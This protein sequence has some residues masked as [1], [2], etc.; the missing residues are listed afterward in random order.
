[1]SSTIK[2]AIRPSFYKS[3][4]PSPSWVPDR[5]ATLLRLVRSER[6]LHLGCADAPLTAAKLGDGGVLHQKV[7]AEAETVLGV[8]I[9]ITGLALLEAHV[10]GEYL[11]IDATD[12]AALVPA[13]STRPTIVLAADIIEHV[14]DT[15]SLLDA[16]AAFSARCA[17]PP[18][19]LLSTPNALSV[20]GPILAAAGVELVHPDHRMIFTPTTLARTLSIAGYRPTSWWTYP[21]S[22]GQS[23][24]RRIFDTAARNVGRLRPTLADGM[25]VLAELNDGRNQP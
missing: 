12:A 15:G 2:A 18:R 3:K 10:G 1:M 7:L 17:P 20:R 11:H 21:V 22:L 23:L 4:L 24:P 6:V 16:L 13:L 9:D 14:G 5:D 19:L 8:D 25:I